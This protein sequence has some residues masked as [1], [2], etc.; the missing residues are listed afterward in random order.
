MLN[1]KDILKNAGNQ[2]VDEF[3]SIY[4]PTI[5]VNADQQLFDCKHSSKYLF[6]FFITCFCV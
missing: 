1:M 3:H 4:F 2:T 5:E 6:N